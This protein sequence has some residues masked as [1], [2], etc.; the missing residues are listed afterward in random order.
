MCLMPITSNSFPCPRCGKERIILKQWQEAS[1]SATV[2][3]PTRHTLMVCP[4]QDCQDK[5]NKDLIIRDAK[6]AALL[7]AKEQRNQPRKKAE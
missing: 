7:L 5:Q 1:E 3:Q 6:R 2:G 4:D